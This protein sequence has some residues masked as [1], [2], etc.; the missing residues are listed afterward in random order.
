MIRSSRDGAIQIF[1]I[2]RPEKKNAFTGAMYEQFREL[3][4]SADAAPEILAM[5]ITGAGSIFSAGNDLEDFL[6]S[7]PNTTDAAPFRFLRT[8][9]RIRKPVVAA[10][11]GPAIGIG[12][13]LLFHCD[14]VYAQESARFSF[15][16][17]SLGLVPEGGSSLLLPRMIGHQRAAA[18][19]LL[20]EAI[21]AT[22]ARQIGLVNALTEQPV[23]PLALEQAHRLAQL[24]AAAIM[25]TK[26]LMK[27]EPGPLEQIEH[28][29]E[30]FVERTGS[31]AAREAFSAFLEKRKPDFKGLD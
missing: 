8:L 23:L 19:L 6:N 9:A 3:L 5:I 21:S 13:T 29:A 18:A 7:P 11:N 14:L 30:A 12:S 15:P 20:G 24:P 1:E 2:C 4:A 28:E 22:E 16:F 25:E 31:A 10:V 17:V 27:R 26:R